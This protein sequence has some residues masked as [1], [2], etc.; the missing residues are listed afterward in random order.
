[1]NATSIAAGQAAERLIARAQTVAVVEAS[2]GGLVS[3]ALLAVP[4]ASA[5]FQG[6]AVVYTA[7]ARRALLSIGEAEMAGIR[8]STEAYAALLARTV[9]D[10]FQS[11]WGIAETGAAGPAGNRYGDPAGHSC[12][13]ICG[14]T[15]R[16]ATVATGHGDRAENMQAFAAA[17]LRLLVEGLTDQDG[18]AKP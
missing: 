12:I 5:Y 6:G 4:G 16:T 1:M 18:G 8:P 7:A 11:T 17:L 2:A 13:A 9:R 3:A 15:T 14:P 10:R